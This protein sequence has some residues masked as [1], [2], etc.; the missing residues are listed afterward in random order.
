MSSVLKSAC[1]LIVLPDVDLAAMSPARV[2]AGK[3]KNKLLLF[4]AAY[5]LIHF[6]DFRWCQCFRNAI[7][8]RQC[9]GNK[10]LYNE[11]IIS[12]NGRIIL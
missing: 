5:H 7:C 2:F 11:I 1:P 9:I 10:S 8:I 3:K 6:F 4:A 12:G